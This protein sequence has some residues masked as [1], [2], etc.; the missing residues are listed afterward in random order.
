MWGAEE[1]GDGAS[2]TSEKEEDD[3]LEDEDELGPGSVVWARV[4]RYHPA[5]V[6]APRDVPASLSHLL[7]KAKQPSIFIKRFLLEDIKLVPVSR[8]TE[9]RRRRPRRSRT[10]TTW[11]WLYSGAMYRWRIHPPSLLS[12]IY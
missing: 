6:V 12:T 1:G 5:L 3:E 9:R 11:P 2:D 7:A 8:S 10:P 4:Q